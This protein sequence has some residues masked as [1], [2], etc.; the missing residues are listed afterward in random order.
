L[1]HV[2]FEPSYTSRCNHL[3]LYLEIFPIDLKRYMN[4][5]RSNERLSPRLVKLIK[6]DYLRLADFGLARQCHMTERTLTHEVVT[7]WYCPT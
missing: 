3:Y 7:L 5:L 1:N 6:I 2:A 4:A